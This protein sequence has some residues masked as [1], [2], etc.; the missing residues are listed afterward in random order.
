MIDNTAQFRDWSAARRE[1]AEQ[2]RRI[3]HHRNPSHM[4]AQSLRARIVELDELIAA[5]SGR[6][7]HD[8]QPRR[9]D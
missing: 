7:R 5:H 4:M 2:L 6:R 8:D 1:Y 9:L 3:E